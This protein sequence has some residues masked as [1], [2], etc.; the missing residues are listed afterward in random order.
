MNIVYD[1]QRCANPESALRHE[2]LETNG[3]GGYASSTIIDCH[4]RKYHGLLVAAL[5]QPRGRFNLLSKVEASL[6]VEGRELS[7]CTNKYPGVFH[8]TGHQYIDRFEQTLAPT[9]T[10]RVGTHVLRKTT[11]M[12]KGENTVLIRY[13]LLE[14]HRRLHLRLKPLLAYRDMHAVI[15]QNMHLRV[16][17]FPEPNGFKIQPYDGMPPLYMAT[18]K[19]STF[20]PGPDWFYRLEYLKE[21]RRGYDYQEDLFCPGLFEV[22]IRVG[23]SVVL[24]ASTTPHNSRQLAAAFKAE[25]ARRTQEWDARGNEADE[26]VRTLKHVA[27]QFLVRTQGRAGLVAGYHW[28]GQWGRDTMLSLP[29]VAFCTGRS[30]QGLDV[31][32]AFAGRTRDGLMPNVLSESGDDDAYNSVDASLLF[33]WAIQEYLRRG[34][35]TDVVRSEFL[36]VMHDIALAHCENRVPHC[37]LTDE[38]FIS[39]GDA[40]TQLTWMDANPGSG[41]VTPRHGAPV[42]VTALWYNALRMLVDLTDGDAPR[43]VLDAMRRVE[44]NFANC[45]WDYEANALGDVY[46]DGVLDGAVRPNQVFAVSLPYSLL[47][48]QQQRAV[49][50]RV[51]ADLLTPFG[52]RTLS[53]ANPA[54]KGRYEG[55]Q[56]QRDAAYHQGT[57]WP[58]LAGHYGEACLKTSSDTR[59]AAAFLRD[60]LAP[61]LKEFPESHA[62]ASLPEVHNGNPPHTPKGCIAQAWSVGEVIRLHTLLSEVDTA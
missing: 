42:E 61:L 57:V 4:T 44:E 49:V 5:D 17:T 47:S 62:V 59:A 21:R 19:R 6:M 52:L 43:I 48:D 36:P 14:G 12:P 10:Y 30:D 54:F 35:S 50:E 11:V 28:F 26:H 33:F 3:L 1:R 25:M 41:P 16:R 58:W 34:G 2:W 46:T 60:R 13:E 38:G 37:R 55:N 56:A 23:D 31:L 20:H 24:A 40:T 27:G 18:S 22:D 9:V 7:L 51:T 8:P 15:R 29:G 53:P 32:R 45:F 39:A